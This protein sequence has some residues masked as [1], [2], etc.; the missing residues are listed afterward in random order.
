VKLHKD[1]RECE[2][3]REECVDNVKMCTIILRQSLGSDQ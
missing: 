2:A 1:L 3:E